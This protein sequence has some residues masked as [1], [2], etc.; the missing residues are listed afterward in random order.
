M[1]E[2]CFLVLFMSAAPSYLGL[3]HR[4]VSKVVMLS[5]G[6]VE[7]DLEHRRNVVALCMFLQNIC[8]SNQVLKAALPR[9][10]VPARLT[11]QDVSVHS[12]CL[13]VPRC[14][15]VQFGESFVVA[16]V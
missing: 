9:V 1:L 11:C 13:V 14:R 12:K 8:V 10:H 2:C 3:I 15:T 16:C 7:C 6:L 5:D 4:V